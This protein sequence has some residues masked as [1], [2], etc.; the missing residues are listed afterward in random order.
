MSRYFW[1]VLP[2]CFLLIGLQ[3]HAQD[4]IDMHS[5]NLQMITD[6]DTKQAQNVLWSLEQLRT[7]FGHIFNRGK[8]YR[9]RPIIVFGLRNAAELK[10]FAGPQTTS[11]G[12]F[13]ISTPDDCNF[14]VLDVSSNDWSAIYRAYTLLL[15]NANY[16]KTHPWFDEGI[17][18]TLAGFSVNDKQATLGPSPETSRIL[19]SSSLIPVGQL[20]QPGVQQTPEFRATAWLVLRW[21]L[22]GNQ[23]EAAAQYFSHVMLQHTPPE[24]AFEQSF[25]ISPSALDAAL[26]KFKASALSPKHIDV[27]A[28]IDRLSFVS[29]KLTSTD[30][31][32]YKARFHL[33]FPNE[34]ADALADLRNLL[35][36]NHDSVIVNR[37]LGYGYLLD[38]NLK[39]AADFIRRAIEL[40]DNDGQ[41]HYLLAVY[42]NQGNNSSI[43]VDSAVPSILLQTDKA[44]SI[45]PELSDAYV[46]MAQ[47]QRSMQRPDLAAKSMNKAMA[48]RPRD[49]NLLLTFASIQAENSKYNDAKSLLGFLQ[50]SS[51]KNVAQRATELLASIDTERKNERKWANK[52]YVDPTEDRWKPTKAADDKSATEVEPAESKIDTRKTEYLKGTL[53]SVSCSDKGATLKVVS[54]KRVWTF[55]VADR[56]KTILI[57][58]DSFE[59]G[60]HAVPVS[61]NFKSS[62]GL[63][64]DIVS[65][66]ID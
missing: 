57:G 52:A 13:A 22:E 24:Q 49:E 2:I 33:A 12:G 61:V 1:K 53:A 8:L 6:A 34:R 63:Q 26:V 37:A 25:S 55:N 3:V 46:L 54:A 58:A 43:Q 65:L 14:L 17:A 5:Q 29:T 30:A 41:M 64:G 60:W 19:Q 31:Q 4:W 38:G 35:A 39:S 45:D 44:L 15:L 40:R 7:E 21:M 66:E 20:V 42:Y 32:A 16:P 11:D 48:M 9:N 50:Q 51:D 23:L 28:G 36:N 47:A 27:P 56:S 10:S 62:G 59:C 18:Q